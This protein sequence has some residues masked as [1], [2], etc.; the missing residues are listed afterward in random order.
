MT[1]CSYSQE[2]DCC[3]ARSQGIS[4]HV[5]DS[6]FPENFGFCTSMLNTFRPRQN[7][8]QFADD[9]FKRILLNENIRIA[10][11]ISLKFIPKGP[12]NNI[13]AF[14]Q[15]IYLSLSEPMMVS[16]LM[17]ICVTGP[18]WVK[19]ENHVC[20]TKRMLFYIQQPNQHDFFS[21]SYTEYYVY[22]FV[23]WLNNIKK[24]RFWY[25]LYLNRNFA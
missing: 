16:L 11:K 14:V 22:G 6:V 12:I 20:L 1:W 15:I 25:M 21:I 18:Q 5:I 4:S 8:R 7:G 9:S 24:E 23:A 17:H 13:P 10:M 2:H 19:P 3:D